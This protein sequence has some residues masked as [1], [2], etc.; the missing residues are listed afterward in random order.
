MS[1]NALTL[2]V[3]ESSYSKIIT[4]EKRVL[5]TKEKLDL[6]ENAD[7]FIDDG[8]HNSVKAH[9]TELIEYSVF[10]FKEAFQSF[11]EHNSRLLNGECISETGLTYHELYA[12]LKD[13][14]LDS[15]FFGAVIGEIRKLNHEV[16]FGQRNV[17]A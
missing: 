15:S 17:C 9:V 12:F 4:G 5:I 16:S 10:G 1:K 7:C 8:T 3:S 14:D 11:M 6:S 13:S 2:S